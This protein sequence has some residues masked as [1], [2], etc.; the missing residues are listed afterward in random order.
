EFTKKSTTHTAQDDSPWWEVDLKAP[1]AVDRIAVWNRTDGNVGN[2]LNNYTVQLLDES[3]NVLWSQTVEQFPNPSQEFAPSGA[4]ELQFAAAYADYEQPSFGASG[5]LATKDPNASGWAVGGATNEPHTLTLVPSSPVQ[6]SS[7]DIIELRIEQ[8][9]QH[10]NHTV[11][12]VGVRLSRDAR[13]A[14]LAQ[15]PVNILTIARLEA[16]NRNPDQQQTLEKHFLENVA[17]SLTMQRERLAA[18]RKL[19][20]EQKPATTVPIYRE[21]AENQLRKTNI[22]IRGNFMALGK[23][24]SPGVPSVFGPLP[25]GAE[26][27]RL[28]LAQWLIDPANPLTAR[29]TVNRFWQQLF[30][31]GI[32]ATPEDFG[33]A[34]ALPTHPELLDWLTIEFR[35]T[36]W[37]VKRMFKLILMSNTYR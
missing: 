2:R 35:D 10:T 6:I 17:P 9:S 16:A 37:D 18:V 14:S 32:V 12:H 36:G 3:R 23:E 22:Q 21:L 1:T 8:L 33:V 26:P 31:R 28:G 29:V 25:E 24:V 4:R 5:V 34:G 7:D 11:G 19:I 15:V 27:N 20:A 30:G 13:A